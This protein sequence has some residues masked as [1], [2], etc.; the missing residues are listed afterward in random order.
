MIPVREQ[1]VLKRWA[2]GE[3]FS[4]TSFAISQ[5]DDDVISYLLGREAKGIQ[6]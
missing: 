6:G 4:I 2:K 5:R 3:T 1:R